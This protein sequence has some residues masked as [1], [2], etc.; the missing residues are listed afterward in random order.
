MISGAGKPQSS[1]PHSAN[2]VKVF[3]IPYISP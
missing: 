1:S 3:S 2:I